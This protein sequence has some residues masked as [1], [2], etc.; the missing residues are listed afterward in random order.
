MGIPEVPKPEPLRARGGAWFESGALRLHLG[1]EP[2]F[3]PARK[4]H[5][6][7]RMR[8]LADLPE[9]ALAAGL[10]RGEIEDLQ[11]VEQ[12]FLD[13]PFGNRIEFVGAG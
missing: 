5:P 12:M 4:A 3:R 9:W 13:D 10:A 2:G 6:A 8:G 1:V 11:G 7:I